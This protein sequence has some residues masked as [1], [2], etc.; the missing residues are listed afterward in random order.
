M[1]V[2]CLIFIAYTYIGYP[3]LCWITA[4]VL[5]RPVARGRIRPRVSVLIAAHRQAATIGLK[6]QSLAAQTYPR[7]LMEVI[8]ACDG[9]DDGTAEVARQVGRARLAG[10]FKLL[11]LERRGKPA[12]LNAAAAAS[13]GEVLVFTDARQPLSP[14]AVQALVEDLADPALGA[15]GGRLVLEGDGPGGAYWRYEA[16]LRQLEARAGVNVGVSGAL[17][18]VRRELFEPLPEETILD[19]AL[20]PARVQLL[21]R[22]VGFEPE[23]Q[24][25]DRTTSAEQ[26]FQRKVRTLA[27]N[28]Q[29]LLLLPA[30]LVPWRNASWFEFISHKLFRLLV[31]YALAGA[32]VAS[33]LLPRPWSPPLVIAQLTLYGLAAA[34]RTGRLRW[35]RLAGLCETLVLLNAA[36][37]VGLVRFVRHGRRLAW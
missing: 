5:P 28:F 34:R 12:A 37:V 30:L 10:R 9:S 31:P 19:D 35:S 23:A 7:A 33:A 27:G 17:Y 24:A 1:L 20:V 8:V 3:I 15:V 11:D 26:E 2:G 25:F 21:G 29:L 22:R 14:T 32:L 4:K 16:F 18:A 36:A 13:R 6:L